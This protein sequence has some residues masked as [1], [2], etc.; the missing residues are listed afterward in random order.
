[1][2]MP[3]VELFRGEHLACK[4]HRA[5]T[6]ELEGREQIH[7][8]NVYH[9]GGHPEE[10]VHLVLLE[11]LED[12]RREGSQMGRE[13]HEC[14]GLCHQHAEFETVDIKH[15]RREGSHYEVIVKMECVNSPVDKIEETLMIE[16]HALRRSCRTRSVNDT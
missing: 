2:V 10:K 7:I 4:P 8:G 1:M 6:F 11:H 13:H 3:I 15:N 16:N 9:D 5:Q 14:A 12:L